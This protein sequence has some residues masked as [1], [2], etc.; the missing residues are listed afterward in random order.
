MKNKEELRDELIQELWQMNKMD[1]IVHLMEFI[2]GETAAL[3]FLSQRIGMRVNPSQISEELN[4]SRAR[5]ANILRS[6]RNKGLIAMEIDDDDRRKMHVDL[7]EAGRD[8][9]R[10]KYAFIVRYFDMYVDVIGEKDISELNR[11]LHKTVESEK[12]L[13]CRQMLPEDKDDR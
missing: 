12:L 3:G 2:E 6:L 10:R 1:I 11:L 4:I 5:T 13:K 9:F 8:F 7:T